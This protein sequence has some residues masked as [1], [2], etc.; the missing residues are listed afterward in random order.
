MRLALEQLPTLPRR[1]RICE[2]ECASVLGARFAMRA[3]RC[4]P[5]RCRGRET[6]HSHV[7][8]GSLGVVGHARQVCCTDG[9]GCKHLQCSAM[10]RQP[11]E[12]RQRL[13]DR[14]SGKL[15]PKGYAARRVRERAR[16]QTFVNKLQGVWSEPFQKPGLR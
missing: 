4:G 12:R 16:G 15:V 7:I 11:P 5:D 13:L 6:Q 10:Q 8:C 3:Q 14:Q 9:R 1:K 2:T